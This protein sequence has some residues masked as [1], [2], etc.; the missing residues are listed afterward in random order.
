MKQDITSQS[1][2]FEEVVD[3]PVHVEFD[4]AHCSTDGGSL[5]LKA[6]DARLGL[7][8]SLA[9][10]L[11]DCRAV[12]RVRH[13]HQDLLRQRVFGIACGYEDCNDAARVG[14][15]PL[16]KLAVGKS[17]VSEQALASQPTLCRFENAIRGRSLLRMAKRLGERVIERHRRRLGDS[18]R[19]ITID[20]DPTDDPTYGTQQLSLFNGHYDS[21]CYLPLACYLS[22]DSEADSY[23]FSYVLQPANV[24]AAQG[25]LAVLKRLIPHLRKSF[26][27]ACLRVRLDGAFANPDLFEYLDNNGLG[28]V[29]AMAANDKLRA[30]AETALALARG[31]STASGVS[32]R[33]FDQCEYAAESWCD[34]YRRVVIKAEV[35]CTEGREPRDNPRFVVTN[36]TASPKHIY[37]RVY[38][39]RGNIENRIK[40][41]LIGLHIDRTSC[42][43]FMAN[44]FRV[45]L[46]AA[47]YVLFQ[48]LRLGAA[49]TSLANAQVWTLRER[50]LKM[51]V[52]VSESTRRIVL[53]LPS[54][55]P[56][57]R[58]WLLVAG[59]LGASPR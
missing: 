45:Q 25:G 33:V 13:S 10:C 41:L 44:Q 38:C 39:A 15:D 6:A 49:G 34:A 48:E 3:K 28:Y 18:C 47:A 36:L 53:H 1:V 27:G 14:G 37:E 59:A 31:A 57:Q 43:R 4:Q 29:V 35:V 46:T 11:D 7:T 56:W 23:L 21:W 51:A 12:E 22:F 32:E 24:T 17:P 20:M 42:H 40:E 30:H 54:N 52:W 9:A 2:L 26:P 16:H 5:L 50:L 19:L 58:E 8:A 55:A